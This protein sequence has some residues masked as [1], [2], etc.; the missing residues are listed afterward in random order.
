MSETAATTATTETTQQTTTQQPTE[1]FGGFAED[2]K[3]YVQNKGFKDPAALADSYRNLEKLVGVREK[4]LQVP[5]DLSSKDMDAV[6]NRLGRPDAPDKYSFKNQDE[7]FDKWS[8]ETF[9]KAGLTANQAKAVAESWDA[10]VKQSDSEFQAKLTAENEKKTAELKTEWG[11]A[12]QQ[13]VN[14]AKNA[15]KTFGLDDAMID[16]MEAAIGFAPVMKMLQT[17]GS[18]LGEANYVSQSGTNGAFGG[19]LTPAQAQAKI[20]ELISD[21]DWSAKYLNGGVQQKE[22]MERLSKMAVG[23]YGS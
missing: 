10:F 23:T 3:G 13:N 17:I 5:D 20:N 2:L 15:A 4:L 16:K 9:H 6:W 12:F 18:K 7:S 1:W 14:L 11:N 21:K 22:E 8:K 19:V